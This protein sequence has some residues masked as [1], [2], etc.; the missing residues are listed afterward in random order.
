MEPKIDR[1]DA[2]MALVLA[3]IFMVGLTLILGGVSLRLVQQG[4]RIDR[5]GEMMN[6]L[7]GLEAAISMAKAE[8]YDL[9][10]LD[11]PAEERDGWVGLDTS[12]NMGPVWRD[13]VLQGGHM[14]GLDDDAV[15]PITMPMMGGVEF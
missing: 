9:A 3:T 5:E 8:L 4:T 11:L 13:H 14:P 10:E 2:G 6:A 7:E 1:S 15:T 12:Y